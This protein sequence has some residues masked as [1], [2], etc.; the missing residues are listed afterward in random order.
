MCCFGVG[1]RAWFVT[2][3]AQAFGFHIGAQNCPKRPQEGA[4]TQICW[5]ARKTGFIDEDRQ[6]TPDGL[7]SIQL[8]AGDGGRALHLPAG[9]EARTDALR[10][11]ADGRHRLA[12]ARACEYS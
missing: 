9:A 4:R 10:D 2:S 6:R 3:N 11:R 5:N 12:S 1:I 7:Q 8:K